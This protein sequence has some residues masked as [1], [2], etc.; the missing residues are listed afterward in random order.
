GKGA[1]DAQAT[2]IPG[3]DGIAMAE[4]AWALSHFETVRPYQTREPGLTSRMHGDKVAGR[5]RARP[6]PREGSNPPHPQSHTTFCCLFADHGPHARGCHAK[7]TPG[8]TES[9]PPE[10]PSEG[11]VGRLSAQRA[12][13]VR[14]LPRVAPGRK[15]QTPRRARRDGA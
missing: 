15:R 14:A 1:T 3:Y 2:S 12:R 11:L 5:I 9:R 10:V 7:T 4:I 13:G 6:G 8:S